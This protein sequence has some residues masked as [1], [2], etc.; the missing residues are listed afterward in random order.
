MFE[1]SIVGSPGVD[2]NENPDQERF[3]C[4][5]LG[6]SLIVLLE[7]MGQ[8]F[9]VVCLGPDCCN[10]QKPPVDEEGLDRRD[11]SWREVG[12]AGSKA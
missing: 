10:R 2:R 6:G 8:A 1:A 12:P 5:G 7:V 4:S 3:V 11:P 9:S